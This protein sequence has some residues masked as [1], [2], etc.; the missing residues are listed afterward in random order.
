M[1]VAWERFRHGNLAS[2]PVVNGLIAVRTLPD[3]VLGHQHDSRQLSVDD[4]DST[5]ER[6]GFRLLVDEPP[7]EFAVGAIGQVWQPRIPF[8]HLADAEAFVAFAD[9]GWIKVAWGIRCTPVA[10]GT[11]VAVELRVGA[12]DPASYRRFRRYFAF[13][14]PFSRYIRRSELRSVTRELGAVGPR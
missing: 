2:S 7:H 11:H 6:P 13:I 8:V 14:G 4:I 3:R 9:P 10:G 12:T 1:P 5:P